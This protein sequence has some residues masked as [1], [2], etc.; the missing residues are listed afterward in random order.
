MIGFYDYTVLLTYLGVASS[1]LGMTFLNQPKL[2]HFSIFCLMFSGLCDM[3]DGKVARTKKNR[4]KQQANFGIQIDSLADVICFGVFPALINYTLSTHKLVGCVSSIMLVLCGI[5]RLGYFN[6]MEEE[7]QKETS[8]C[9]KYYQGLPITAT[10]IILP[11]AYLV[12]FLL[13]IETSGGLIFNITCIIT[14]ILNVTD[15]KF[16]KPTTREL[17]LLTVIG[18][19]IV[20]AILKVGVF[21]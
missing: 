16:K 18:M 4:T 1:V 20:I 12:K 10:A 11:T 17:I 8:E 15:F 21:R 5:I 2:I 9:R 7:R 3:F 13:R 19:A 6:V 14:A